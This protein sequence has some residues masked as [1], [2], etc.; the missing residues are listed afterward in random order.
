MLLIRLEYK[1]KIQLNS[2]RLDVEFLK[3]KVVIN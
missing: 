3:A 1:K 2:S